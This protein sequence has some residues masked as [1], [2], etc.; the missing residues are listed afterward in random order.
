MTG[1]MVI[2]PSNKTF[3]AMVSLIDDVSS[4]ESEQTLVNHYYL[5]R[6]N[7]HSDMLHPQT[8]FTLD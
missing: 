4:E 3:E 5:D 7:L 8:H 6:S 2:E 1:F